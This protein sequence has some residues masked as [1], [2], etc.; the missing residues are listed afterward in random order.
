MNTDRDA[1]G[2]VA[3]DS[4]ALGQP[5]RRSRSIDDDGVIKNCLTQY[6]D[7][8][9]MLRLGLEFPPLMGI[10]VAIAAMDRANHHQLAMLS[11]IFAIQELRASIADANDAR[12]EDGLLAT[13]ICLCV[14]ESF[15]TDS[16][17][18]VG[19]H[20]TAAGFL[21]TSRSPAQ[22]NQQP[23]RMFERICV[24][25][26][27]Y[28]SALMMLFDP[29]FDALSNPDRRMYLDRYFTVPD[30]PG[31]DPS[32]QPILCTSYQFFLLIADVTRLAR[33]AGLF[34]HSDMFTW[35]RLQDELLQWERNPQA[36]SEGCMLYIL[37]MRILLIRIDTSAPS[38]EVE[39]RISFLLRQ[40]LGLVQ[41]IDA[42]QFL[43]GD[44][45]WP[46]AVL[47]SVAVTADEI[48]ILND[49]IASLGSR[50]ALAS[51]VRS[52]LD[53]IRTMTSSLR[54]RLGY[55][56]GVGHDLA[57]ARLLLQY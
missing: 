41:S 50:R 18:N 12:N 31:E 28:H 3:V 13:T 2:A 49:K 38:E 11:Y 4:T 52:H 15:R 32:T 45:L 51:W 56:L 48:R 21:L 24:E 44:L 46:L 9:Y 17:P 35:Q 14:Y 37:A 47:G 10:M 6:T 55:L 29:T 8:S 57:S 19:P 54:M 39:G 7:Q 42:D 30:E 20:A 33:A 25:S 1:G 5:Q 40:G 22:R 34:C 23:A 53:K 43:I 36:Q 27:L 16:P 26:F